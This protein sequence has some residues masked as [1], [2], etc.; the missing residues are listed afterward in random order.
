[1]SS[2]MLCRRGEGMGSRGQEVGRLDLTSL[3][4][5]SG[6]RGEKEARPG[7]GGSGL[8]SEVRLLVSGGG[9]EELMSSTF[10][11][12]KV[13]KSSAER[14]DGAGGEGGLRR[15]EKVENSLLG[16]EAE[17]WISE[18]KKEVFAVETAEVKLERM[19][20]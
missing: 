3:R 14:E 12:K 5:S 7:G 1:M 13:T 9:K 17:D 10:F 11:A 18:I 4:T 19:R 20:W 15:E 2:E 8:G 16:L 6:E